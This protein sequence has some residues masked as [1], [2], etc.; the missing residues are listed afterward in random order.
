MN[1]GLRLKQSASTS[2]PNLITAGRRLKPAGFPPG[3][4]V[5]DLRWYRKKKPPTGMNNITNIF[6][7]VYKN[8][9]IRNNQA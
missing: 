9:I 6:I 4:I 2:E 7:Q 1:S 8:Y 5:D 3:F